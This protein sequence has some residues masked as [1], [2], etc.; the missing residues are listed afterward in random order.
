M[1]PFDASHVVAVV[2]RSLLPDGRQVPFC[3][4]TSSILRCFGDLG[5]FN[6]SNSALRFMVSTSVIVILVMRFIDE[7]RTSTDQRGID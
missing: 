1:F 5:D 4:C 2:D 7:N 6:E 3:S